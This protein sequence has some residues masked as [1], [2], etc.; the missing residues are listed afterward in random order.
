MTVSNTFDL[1]IRS[2]R[3]NSKLGMLSHSFFNDL[4]NVLKRRGQLLLFVVTESDIVGDLTIIPNGIHGIN[5]LNSGFLEFSF[6]VK[7]TSFIDNDI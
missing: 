7:N 6:F 3:S 1:D 5:K 2:I 4:S